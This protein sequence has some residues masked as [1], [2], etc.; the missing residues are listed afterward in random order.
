MIHGEMQ[1]RSWRYWR[2]WAKALAA[3]VCIVVIIVL[4]EMA[5]SADDYF[6]E[7][8]GTALLHALGDF[9][10]LFVAFASLFIVSLPL[11]FLFFWVAERS[12]RRRAGESK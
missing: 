2:K 1:R 7:G 10:Y 9:I 12:R 5:V 4:I 6:D 3:F 11:L 8:I